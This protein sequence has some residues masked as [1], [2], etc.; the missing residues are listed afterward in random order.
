[1]HIVTRADTQVCPEA[2]GRAWAYLG[3][4]VAA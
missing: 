2:F 4:L 3:L 1:M